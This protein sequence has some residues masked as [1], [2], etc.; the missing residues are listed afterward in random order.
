LRGSTNSV[1]AVD[2]RESPR[3]SAATAPA[4]SSSASRFAIRRTR[5]RDTF[6]CDE[7]NEYPDDART[8]PCGATARASVARSRSVSRMVARR[9]LE[10][11]GSWPKAWPTR[12]SRAI[13]SIT[14]S[15]LP[16]IAR[17]ALFTAYSLSRVIS[18]LSVAA[19]T[20]RHDHHRPRSNR[21]PGQQTDHREQPSHRARLTE[22]GERSARDRLMI[23][24]SV[25]AR[26]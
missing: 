25:A 24:C 2:R 14:R 8:A 15:A 13:S 23:G 20:D 19:P 1:S 12:S 10:A 16:A 9:T 17:R 11:P 18:S 26:V 21:A 6:V 7:K 5:A 4:F 22:P 3:I